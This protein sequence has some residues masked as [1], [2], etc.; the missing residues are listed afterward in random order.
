MG[1]MLSFTQRSCCEGRPKRVTTRS[2]CPLQVKQGVHAELER[3]LWNDTAFLSG[4]GAMDY[5]LLVGVD[6]ATNTLVVGII[7]FIRQVRHQLTAAH[8]QPASVPPPILVTFPDVVFQPSS[9]CRSRWRPDR[10][11]GL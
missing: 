6:K 1:R 10:I 9:C 4:L 11:Q 5:S 3:A 8:P 2:A 7:D